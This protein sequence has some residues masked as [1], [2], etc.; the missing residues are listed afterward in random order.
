MMRS[1][2]A[3][4]LLV[5]ARRTSGIGSSSWP[6]PAACNPNDGE[7]L[8]KWLERREKV[9]L[10]A[11]NGNG[12][13]TPLSIAAK[14]W[15]TPN[16]SDAKRGPDARDR[17]G[18]GGPNLAYAAYATPTARDWKSCR[19]SPETH[20]KNSRPLSEQIG[21]MEGNGT[22][23]QPTT[24]NPEWVEWLM[25]FPIGWTDCEDSATR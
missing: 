9:K 8:E 13:G 10:T 23:T 24:L 21:A 7:P 17:P 6:T 1:G 3:Y 15:P 20:A 2:I 16:T 11:K 5:L 22:Q 19:A 18:S 25:G 12:M 4:R 14:M